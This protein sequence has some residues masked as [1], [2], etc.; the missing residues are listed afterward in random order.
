MI[1]VTQRRKS[2]ATTGLGHRTSHS[3]QCKSSTPPIPHNWRERL[4]DPAT[5]YAKHVWHLSCTKSNGF[6]QGHCPFH[7]DRN[8]SLSV[9]VTDA[10]GGWRCFAGCGGGDLVA[11]HMKR[12]GQNFRDAVASLLRGDA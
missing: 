4:P 11:F 5:Y 8:S 2:P 3:N 1:P 7:D 12:T 9:N 6:A 10:R